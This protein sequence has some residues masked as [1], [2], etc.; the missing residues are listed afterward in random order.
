MQNHVAQ[1]KHNEEFSLVLETHWPKKY[2]DWRITVLFYTALHYIRALEKSKNL[3]FGTNH[4]A[5]KQN[6]HPNNGGEMPV[7]QNCYDAYIDM[8]NS[9]YTS[10]YTG[11]IKASDFNALMEY[12]YGRCETSLRVIKAYCLANGV[13]I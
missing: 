10:R 11:F 13:N 6:I 4:K 5:T 9:A 3:N 7:S 1:A 12:E 8:F 2:F